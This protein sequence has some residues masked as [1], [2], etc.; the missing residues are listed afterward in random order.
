MAEKI[1]VSVV[2]ASGIRSD[3]TFR[4]PKTYQAVTGVLKEAFGVGCLVN[5]QGDTLTPDDPVAAG[6]YT[7]TVTGLVSPAGLVEAVAATLKAYTAP[8]LKRPKLPSALSNIS[9]TAWDYVQQDFELQMVGLQPN[10]L[11][12]VKSAPDVPAYQWQ[13]CREDDQKDAYMLYIRG[14]IPLDERTEWIQGD[15]HRTLLNASQVHRWPVGE[16]ELYHLSGTTDA[17]AVLTAYMSMG[18]PWEGIRLTIEVKKQIVNKWHYEAAAQLICANITSSKFKPLA[19]LT[20]LVDEWHLKYMSGHK[21]CAGRF[22]SRAAA[23]ACIRDWLQKEKV[24]ETA[25]TDEPLQVAEVSDP[26][27]LSPILKRARYTY[28]LPVG[29]PGEEACLRDLADC[30]PKEEAY[31]T[32]K[33]QRELYIGN[34]ATGVVNAEMLRELFNAVLSNMVP[35][36]ITTPPVLD[37]KIDPTGRY[38]PCTKACRFSFVELRTAALALA[39]LHLDKVELCGRQLNIGRPKG[40]IEPPAIEQQAKLTMAQMF[41]AQVSGGPTNVVLLENLMLAIAVQDEAAR[42]ELYDDVYVEV[43]KCGAVAGLCIPTPPKTLPPPTSCRVYIRFSA[44]EAATRCKAM[45]D[46]REFDGNLVKVT[47]VESYKKIASVWVYSDSSGATMAEKIVVSVVDASG[48]RSDHT[49]RPPKTYQ[50]VTGVLKEAFGVGCLVNVQ[51]DTLTPDDPVAAGPYTYTVTGLVSPAGLVEAVAATLKAYTAPTLKRPK[52][53]SALSNISQTAWDYVQ[54]DFELQMVGLQP[55]DLPDVKSAPDVPAYQWQDCREDD[56][57]DAY[58]LYIRGII[59]LDERTEWIQGDKHRT[60]LNASQ[61]HRWPVGEAELYHLSG[62]T[63]AAAVLTAYMSMGLPWEGIRLT[64]EVKKQIVNKWHYEAAA[65]LICAN[66]TSSK[67]KPLAILTDLVDEWHLKYMSGHKLCAGRF[68][69]RAAAVACIR[70]WLQKEKVVE[71]AETDEPL[72]VAEVSDPGVLSPILKRARYT[73]RLPVGGPGEEACLRDLADCLPKEEAYETNKKQRELYI[74]NLATGVVNAEMLRELFNAVLSNMVPDPI[75]TPPVLDVKID[76]TGRY[77]PCTKACRFS[78][79]ELRTAALALA[80]LH[81]DKVELCGRQLNIGRPKGY[82]EPPAIEQQAKL[83]MAQMFAAQVSGGPTNVVLLENLMLAIAVQDEAARRE[84]YDDV[85]VEVVKCGAVAGLCIPTPPKTLPPPTSC[86]VYIRFSAQEAAT[87]CKA[88][89]DG[90]EFDGN[91]VKVTYVESYKKIASVWVYSDSSGATMAEKI[92][93]SVVDASGIR[94]DHT[95]RPPKTYQAVTGVLKEAFGVGCLVNVQ[96]DTL[97]PDDPVAAGP[98]TYTVTGLVSPAGLVEAVAATLKAYTAPTL[99]RPKLP[100]ALSNISQTAWDYVQQDFELQMVGLQPN[101]LPDVKSAPD[102]P[103]YQWQDCREDDQKDAYM[104]YI[105]GIIPLDERTGSG[106]D[107][108]YKLCLC[109]DAVTKLSNYSGVGQATTAIQPHLNSHLDSKPPPLPNHSGGLEYDV[110]HRFKAGTLSLPHLLGTAA[111]GPD[112][113]EQADCSS[114]LSCSRP[115]VSNK[116]GPVSIFGLVGFCCCH[117]VPALGLFCNMPTPEQ[118]AFYLLALTVIM[119]GGSCKNIDFFI[120]FGCRLKTTWARYVD[121][122]GKP[123]SWKAVRIMVNWMHGAS[124]NQRCQVQNNGRHQPGSGWR[125]GEQCEQLWSMLKAI[126][127]LT[128][129]MSLAH[130]ADVLQSRLSQIAFQKSVGLLDLLDKT[131]KEMKVKSGKVQRELEQLKLVAQQAG[132]V[133]GKR[134]SEAYKASCLPASPSIGAHDIHAWK[135]EYVELVL[136]EAAWLAMDGQAVAPAG[137]AVQLPSLSPTITQ[138]LYCKNWQLKTFKNKL[139]RLE[140]VNRI[141]AEAGISQS[142]MECGLH[143]LKIEKISGCQFHIES[144]VAEARQL[145]LERDREGTACKETRRKAKAQARKL[146]QAKEELLSM[147]E[148][149]VLGTSQQVASVRIPETV[150]SSM[151]SGSAPPWAEDAASSMAS[152]LHHGKR[153]FQLYSDQERIAEQQVILR[154]ELRRFQAWLR[155]MLEACTRSSTE[156]NPG[157]RFYVE[158]HKAWF[159]SKLEHAYQLQWEA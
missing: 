84:L 111:S 122:G 55:N 139:Q 41:A 37:V 126:A 24:V 102:V 65:Q 87:R 101:D 56:Q 97:T 45:M 90:R 153:Y 22:P 151:V 15:K 129:Y 13:D 100:S 78:F 51:G 149:Q 8:T 116:S 140:L 114:S 74:G 27:V 120:D 138:L 89:M 61:V 70:D 71:T 19:I 68:P 128:R 109:G 121:A 48:I 6:P 117:G 31:E 88:M 133:D 106:E 30:L 118:F 159:A 131:W 12:D 73:Y 75:T 72:Q 94:S 146:L 145:Q 2:D 11:P 18:L 46:G 82:I 33:K 52:L 92:V 112:D 150:I 96:G 135:R 137:Q 110:Q 142:D 85:Y 98:Y 105:R 124:H 127:G 69:S 79:V 50:A 57:K 54:Q 36:P 157:Q 99:K 155:S 3:H 119:A 43:V 39:A 76:P 152:T 132:V 10:D 23:V 5:V 134:A 103:A 83:T 77:L 20:D 40:Y 64:I 16:A 32:N 67:F 58:M 9:Q 156:L 81:L 1:V 123:S 47:Y 28:R 53:P 25:E 107:E 148:W 34:L 4:P 86:R 115:E 26:G 38:L 144:L 21:L 141:D 143:L 154:Q 93:V 158:Q 7:Y 49:F 14:I 95:F 113:T 80:A 44:Q 59:P 60:L 104:L 42:R 66:I 29:G 125:Y 63:D 136:Q 17:A 130:R 108:D 35:D 62:T 147:A 91:L